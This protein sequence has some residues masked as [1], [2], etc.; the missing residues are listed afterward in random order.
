MS[1]AQYDPAKVILSVGGFVMKQFAADSMVTISYSNPANTK[2][3]GVDGGGRWASSKDDSGTVTITLA[4]YSAS[5]Q[6]LTTLMKADQPVPITLVDKSS[7]G[8]GFFAD[9]CKVEDRPDMEKAKEN[10]ENTW[11]FGFIKG[12]ANYAGAKQV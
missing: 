1:D 5:N 10:S 3:I 8:D 7:D 9:S 11:V 4:A 6:V 12:E 2:H